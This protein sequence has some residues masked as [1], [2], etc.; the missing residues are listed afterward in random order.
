MGTSAIQRD[1]QLRAQPGMPGNAVAPPSPFLGVIPPWMWERPKRLW[2]Q[3]FSGATLT[4]IAAGAAAAG[5]FVVDTSLY[6]VAYYGTI[7]VRANAAGKAL[8]T[9][10]PMTIS[11][12]TANNELFNPAQVPNDINNVLGTAA[13]PSVWSLPMILQP[14]DTL[15]A[16]L[17]NNHNATA[18]D[19]ALSLMG[20]LVSR[21]DRQ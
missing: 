20:F 15:V 3:P 16:S 19:V 2:M 5:Q 11:F 21:G 7:T 13:Q 18:V 17:T 6:F 1:V 14:G 4:N 8:Q 9:G 10:F 12:A